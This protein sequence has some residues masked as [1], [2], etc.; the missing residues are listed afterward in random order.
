VVV[1]VVVLVLEEQNCAGLVI[2]L[3]ASAEIEQRLQVEHSQLVFVVAQAQEADCRYP[4]VV[5]DHSEQVN[6]FL[7]DEGMEKQEKRNKYEV[8]LLGLNN[9]FVVPVVDMFDLQNVNDPD[10]EEERRR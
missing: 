9:H 2:A 7:V 1:V 8:H 6:E 4:V 5:V 10:V 3:D